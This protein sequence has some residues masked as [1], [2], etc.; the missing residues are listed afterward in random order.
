MSVLNFKRVIV[1]IK[2]KAIGA[3]T[4]TVHYIFL[5]SFVLL[6]INKI[7]THIFLNIGSCRHQACG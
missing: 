3:T 6:L 5:N 1:N 4:S 2:I 7:A